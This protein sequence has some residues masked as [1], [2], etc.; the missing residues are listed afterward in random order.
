MMVKM[1]EEVRDAL[2]VLTRSSPVN[3]VNAAHILLRGLSTNED[4]GVVGRG[5]IRES[6][7]GVTAVLDWISVGDR[8]ALVPTVTSKVG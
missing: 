5:F 7:H 6:F 4:I 8:E 1:T 3:Q 2:E